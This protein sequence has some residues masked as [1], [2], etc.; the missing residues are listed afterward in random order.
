MNKLKSLAMNH[1]L[2]EKEFIQDNSHCA[3]C[4]ADM[5]SKCAYLFRVWMG[6]LTASD[7]DD[8]ILRP[9]PECKGALNNYLYVFINVCTMFVVRF[10]ITIIQY[11]D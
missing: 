8:T 11:D 10:F 9:H 1:K 3:F 7:T 2:I 5:E 6:C 4:V